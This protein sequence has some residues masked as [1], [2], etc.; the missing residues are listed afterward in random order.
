MVIFTNCLRYD[1]GYNTNKMSYGAH[2]LFY[3]RA[4]RWRFIYKIFKFTI[5]LIYSYVKYVKMINIAY[6]KF[7]N[8]WMLKILEIYKV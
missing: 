4:N 2:L 1:V 7:Q 6:V 8:V 3:Y 5:H